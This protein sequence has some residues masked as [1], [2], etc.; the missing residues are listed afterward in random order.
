MT[1]AVELELVR[2]ANRAVEGAVTVCVAW[3]TARVAMAAAQSA[4]KK[5]A[6]EIIKKNGN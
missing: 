5:I 1:E 2:V 3:I 4:A 6:E